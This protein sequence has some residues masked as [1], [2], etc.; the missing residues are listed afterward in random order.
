MKCFARV[1]YGPHVWEL[2]PAEV[3]FPETA[4]KYKWFARALLEGLVCPPLRH[5]LVR[6]GRGEKRR[7]GEGRGGERG[8][9]RGG[10]ESGGERSGSQGVSSRVSFVLLCVTFW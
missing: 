2:P 8:R 5:F 7:G 10:E 9:E 3:T 1:S 4:D 6:R